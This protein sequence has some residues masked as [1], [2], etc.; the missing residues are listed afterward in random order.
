VYL[1]DEAERIYRDKLISSR[2]GFDLTLKE[3]EDINQ[4]VS[5]RIFALLH[6][7]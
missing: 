7:P 5:P 4:K 1:A 6:L 2:D 3:L